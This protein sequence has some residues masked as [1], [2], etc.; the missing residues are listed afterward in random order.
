MRFPVR[1][2]KPFGNIENKIGFFF[3][4][5]FNEFRIGFDQ[6]NFVFFLA[7]NRSDGLYRFG[8]VKFFKRVL[9]KILRIVFGRNRF[10]EIERDRYFHGVF[11]GA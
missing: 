1:A 2:F 10:F 7:E 11:P 9:R 8:R 5:F 4:D 3:L 6:N